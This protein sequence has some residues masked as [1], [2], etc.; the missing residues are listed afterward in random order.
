MVT[1]FLSLRHDPS[2]LL[3][4]NNR[5]QAYILMK[6]YTLAVADCN[7]VLKQ[8][9]SNSKALYRRANAYCQMGK[10]EEARNDVTHILQSDPSNSSATSLLNQ[11]C[12][13][14]RYLSHSLPRLL[15]LTIHSL[16][17]LITHSLTQLT[18]SLTHYSLTTHVALIVNAPTK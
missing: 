15:V 17:P 3:A 1:P 8:E 12:E 13:H 16:T 9:P 7:D 2:Y 18:H 11:I 5:A 10:H 4:K 14:Y 6:E